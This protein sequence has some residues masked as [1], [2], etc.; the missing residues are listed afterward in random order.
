MKEKSKKMAD[1]RI[2]ELTAK[3]R[4][5]QANPAEVAEL[6]TLLSKPKSFVENQSIAVPLSEDQIKSNIQAQAK[7]ELIAAS[8]SDKPTEQQLTGREP[9]LDKKKID[10]L[11]K[12]K[13]EKLAGGDFS[14]LADNGVDRYQ[15]NIEEARLPK[16]TEAA[17]E[18]PKISESLVDTPAVAAPVTTAS[19]TITTPSGVELPKE[20]V[21]KAVISEDEKNPSFG[22]K[23]KK[24]AGTYGVPILEIL[25]AVGYQRGGINK[26]TIL[27]QKFQAKLDKEEKDYMARLEEK[28][29]A[30][31][32][33][34]QN[35]ILKQQ[36]DFESAQAQ[37]DRIAAKE[38]AGQKLSAD[39]RL[40]AMQ[41]AAQGKSA[42]FSGKSLIPE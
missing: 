16:P 26:P 21:E 41:L 35:D 1:Q 5:G 40:L 4:A 38:A 8:D 19:E 9:F 22:Q 42:K 28:K 33:K 2:N 11:T 39:E 30:A 20:E 25:Q 7:K 37:L 13:M 34:Y 18:E 10:P 29:L 12:Q 3:M 36:Q 24:L 31:Q 17:V 27:E 6:K 32:Q 14:P 15:K 23:L